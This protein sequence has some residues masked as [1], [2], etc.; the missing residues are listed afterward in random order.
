MMGPAEDTTGFE[1]GGINSSE[2][3]KLYNN[4]QLKS[5]QESNLGADIG[6]GVISAIGQAD[7]VMLASHSLH[8]LQLLVT[9]TEQYCAKFRVK[10]EPNKTKLLCYS[11]Q[12]QTF[13]VDH[14]LNTQEITIN[15]MPVKLVSEA[16]HV[17]VLRSNSGNLPHLVNRVAMHKSALH[18]LLPAG[19]AR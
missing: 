6:S 12:K 2:F 19:M 5:A 4:E 13:I 7:D 10:L 9:L 18:A 3:Y 8:S 17:G 16:E 11:N 14:A 15:N 1:Q